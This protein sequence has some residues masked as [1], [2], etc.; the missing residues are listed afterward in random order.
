MLMTSGWQ[1]VMRSKQILERGE[2]LVA[3]LA[4]VGGLVL[5][6]ARVRDRLDAL[7]HREEHGQRV[8]VA[9]QQLRGFF[10]RQAAS[11]SG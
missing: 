3:Q 5:G 9:R 4:R 7:E 11:G 10:R 1:S 2:G 6:P 8:H